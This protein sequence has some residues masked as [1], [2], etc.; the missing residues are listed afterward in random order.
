MSISLLKKVHYSKVEFTGEDGES[1]M[2]VV[3]GFLAMIDGDKSGY[4]LDND[5]PEVI[6]FREKLKFFA[7][8]VRA[9]A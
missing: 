9:M 7:R 1:I 5:H 8:Q 3:S 2:D 4:W 6:K